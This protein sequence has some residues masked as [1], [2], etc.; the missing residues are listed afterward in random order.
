MVISLIFNSEQLSIYAGQDLQSLHSAS[1]ATWTPES[2][3]IVVHKCFIS[4]TQLLF[5]VVRHSEHTTELP[6]LQ[7]VKVQMENFE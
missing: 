2:A 5:S 1:S 6:I 3:V 7:T 4:K